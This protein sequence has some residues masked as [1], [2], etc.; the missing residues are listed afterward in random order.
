M[1]NPFIKPKLPKAVLDSLVEEPGFLD[2]SP[3]EQDS[4]VNEIAQEKFGKVE[5]AEGLMGRMNQFR[6]NMINT[7]GIG[8]P[9]TKRAMEDQL[10]TFGGAPREDVVDNYTMENRTGLLPMVGQVMGGETA[11]GLGATG[12]AMIGQG[13][14]QLIRAIPG[15]KFITPGQPNIGDVAKEGL[16]TGAIEGATRGFGNQFFKRQIAATKLKNSGKYIEDANETL[17][18]GGKKY[19]KISSLRSDILKKSIDRDLDSVVVKD[20]TVYNRLKHFSEELGNRGSKELMPHEIKAFEQMIGDATNFVKSGKDVTNR[21]ANSVAKK[22]GGYLSDSHDELAKRAGFTDIKK[23]NKTTS[24][25]YS[26]YPEY[27][28]S[29]AGAGFG[30][31]LVTSAAV[32]SL[33]GNPL[34]GAGTYLAEKALQSPTF[35]NAAYKAVNNPFIKGIGKVAKLG[36][37]AEARKLLE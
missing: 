37:T 27:D 30:T 36:G 11:G 16:V 9:G 23:H 26:K 4:L 13:A 33:T 20:G 5:P 28:P 17:S 24:D 7:P 10:I 1:A 25:I 15:Q 3:E 34:I 22:W 8:G 14:N 2:L 31:R 12:G 6:E 21:E 32:G 29:K 35:K 19:P 18:S